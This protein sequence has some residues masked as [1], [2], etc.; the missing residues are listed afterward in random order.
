M[1]L[2][3]GAARA[4]GVPLAPAAGAGRQGSTLP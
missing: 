3:P 1:P 4:T 2:P